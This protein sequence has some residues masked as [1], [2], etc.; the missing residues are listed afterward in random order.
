MKKNS[1]TVKVALLL[2][3]GAVLVASFATFGILFFTYERGDD[4]HNE[5]TLAARAAEARSNGDFLTAAALYNRLMAL[6][7]FEKQHETDYLHALVGLRDFET[8]AAAT[9]GASTAFVLTDEEK[10]VEA[11]L[12]RGA[13]LANCQSNELAVAA[14]ASVTNLNAFSVTP[15]LIQAQAKAGHPDL[16]LSIALDYTARFPHPLILRQAAEWSALARRRDLVTTCRD[17]S[18]RVRGRTGISVAHYCDALLAWLDGKDDELARAVKDLNGEIASP[19]TRLLT[20]QCT[21]RDGTA[22]AVEKAYDEA[23]AGE[24]ANSAIVRQARAA[25]K[26][27]LA[28]RFPTKIKLDE[29]RRLTSLINDPANPDVDIL[30]LSLLV[31]AVSGTLLKRELEDAIRRFPNDR[32]LLLISRQQAQPGSQS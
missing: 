17:R 11:A 21:A 30:R 22:E 5:D 26:S 2:I 4:A 6:N 31:K 24:P 13:A 28:S 9:N 32:G 25:V 10:A 14:F 16:A 8:L 19:L 3:T 7:P 29:I 1:K 20:L 12:A 23:V 27:F 15:F 18:L